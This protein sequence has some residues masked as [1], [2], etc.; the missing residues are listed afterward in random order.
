MSSLFKYL[1]S[2]ICVMLLVTACS[3]NN[4]NDLKKFVI[5]AEQNA[6]KRPLAALPKLIA[7]KPY[8]Y[9]RNSKRNPF[10]PARL[11]AVQGLIAQQ[12]I[13]LPDPNRK[14][15][16][17]EKYSISTLKLVG[18]IK[19]QNNYWALI[20]NGDHR[21][22]YVVKTGDY[23]GMN[24]GEIIKITSKNVVVKEI[25]QT[26]EGMW[27]EKNVELK[28]TADDQDNEISSI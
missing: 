19:Q 18:V 24:H 20:L 27:V 23:V 2:I 3:K 10:T 25:Q 21:T 14:K 15:G 28:L 12:N 4:D 13:T 16:P 7:Y 6:K 22:V 11:A 17:L 5:N 1:A 9:E 8:S 26:I